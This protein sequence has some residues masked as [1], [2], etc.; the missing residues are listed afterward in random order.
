MDPMHY[1]P[2]FMMPASE[3]QDQCDPISPLQDA[4][5]VPQPLQCTSA[6]HNGCD[7]MQQNTV[8]DLMAYFGG[9]TEDM[10]PPAL[11]NMQPT[12]GQ[13]FELNAQGFA[14]VEFSVEIADADPIVGLSWSV[15]S[16]VFEE[17]FGGTLQVCTNNHCFINL[18]EG[19]PFKPTG[20]EW[21]FPIDLPGG[22]YTVTLEASDYHGN[23]AETITY[24]FTVNG[25][26]GESGDVTDTDAMTT[27]ATMTGAT[28]TGSDTFLEG[29]DTDAETEGD[30]DDGDPAMDDDSGCGCTQSSGAGGAFM[31]I[32]GLFGFAATRRRD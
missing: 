4:K 17:D 18:I 11:S 3:F 30:E 32:L 9:R 22:E 10:D 8:A 20:S 13:D 29:S 6:D 19:D 28:M 24:T 26:M 1:P 15:E 2:D 31:L 27:S 5:M 21:G 14:T 16:S 7:A 12:D 23:V 25:G